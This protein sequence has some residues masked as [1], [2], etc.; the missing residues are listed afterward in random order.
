MFY[1]L[2]TLYTI[3]LKPLNLVRVQSGIKLI[4]KH[5]CD[6]LSYEYEIDEWIRDSYRQMIYDMEDDRKFNHVVDLV[7]TCARMEAAALAISIATGLGKHCE[8]TVSMDQRARVNKLFATW[9]NNDTFAVQIPARSSL[10]TIR[11]TIPTEIDF[12][13][14]IIEAFINTPIYYP[15]CTIAEGD[16]ARLGLPKPLREQ[17]QDAIAVGSVCSELLMILEEIRA[18]ATISDDLTP[19]LKEEEEEEGYGDGEASCEDELSIDMQ[20]TLCTKRCPVDPFMRAELALYD[21]VEK[22]DIDNGIKYRVEPSGPYSIVPPLADDNCAHCGAKI[23]KQLSGQAPPDEYKLVKDSTVSGKILITDCL[24]RRWDHERDAGIRIPGCGYT[25]HR[26]CTKY[27]EWGDKKKCV[28]GRMECANTD[29]YYTWLKKH[30]TDMGLAG[31]SHPWMIKNKAHVAYITKQKNREDRLYCFMNTMKMLRAGEDFNHEQREVVLNMAKDNVKRA[32]SN[33]YSRCIVNTMTALI[34]YIFGN[35]IKVYVKNVPTYSYIDK[36]Q[37]LM[38]FE[39]GEEVVKIYDTL[40][41][42]ILSKTDREDPSKVIWSEI[43]RILAQIAMNMLYGYFLHEKHPLNRQCRESIES[44]LCLNNSKA[45]WMLMNPHEE[46]G[47]R[48]PKRKRQLL[49]HHQ[50]KKPR[51][52]E[53]LLQ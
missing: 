2:E 16:Y 10:K 48:I 21:G 32:I 25:F 30:Y 9:V 18:N 36:H 47:K 27:D 50:S 1:S 11:R 28:C 23:T 44:I 52:V 8:H 14:F 49:S 13:Y 12:E 22:V 38:T 45:L 37:K 4:L 51:K 17:Y 31:A 5:T 42:W 34:Q 46:E 29:T 40:L 15:R 43:F 3:S 6:C 53:R 19:S 39:V 33:G 24:S 26:K 41:E 20:S 35:V 7:Y